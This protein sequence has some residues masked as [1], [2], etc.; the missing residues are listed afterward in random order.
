MQIV[1]VRHGESEANRINGNGY[2]MYTGQWDCSLT[3]HGR[4]QAMQLKDAPIFD[5]AECYFVSDLKR[6]RETAA[7]FAG[8]SRIVFDARLRERSLGE[9]EGKTVADIQKNPRYFR[10]FNDP[11]YRH[12]S[13][14][15]V[16]KAPGGENYSDVCE[17]VKAFLQE[18][19]EKEYHKIV[20]VSHICAIRCMLREIRGLSE[21]DTLKIHI[22]TCEPFLVEC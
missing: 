11:A 12:F 9:L 21:E 7:C 6:T 18:V 16:L 2:R 14:D 4:E 17:R 22:P 19:K 8:E 13:H 15:F 3:L 1:F 20:V 5:G 10:L